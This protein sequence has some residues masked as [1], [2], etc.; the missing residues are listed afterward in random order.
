MPLALKQ[1][2]RL[3]ELSLDDVC[4]KYP[5]FPRLIAT[6]IDVQRRGVHYT[7]AALSAV[8]PKLHQVRGSYIFGARDGQLTPVPESL[9][10]RDGTTI[11][12]DTAPIEHNPYIVDLVDG[13]LWLTD[14]GTAVEPVELWPEPAYYDKVTSSGVPMKYVITARPQ[15]LNIFQ[16]GYCHFWA[17]GKGCRYCDIVTHVK[18]QRKEWGIPTRLRPQDVKET[19]IEALKEPGR[20]TNICLTAGSDTRG[21]KAFDSEVSFYIELLQAVGEV[22]KTRR[23]PSQLIATAFNEE[24]LARLYIETG[25]TSYTADIEVLNEDIFNWVCPGKAEWVGYKEW[26]RRLAAAV[27]IFGRG[28]VGNGLVGGVELARPQGFK[29]E[30]EALQRTLEEASELANRGVTTVY[31]VWV[32][33]PGSDFKDQR[34]ASLEYYVRLA[35]GLHDLRVEYGLGVDFDDYRRCGNHPDSDLARLL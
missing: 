2:S 12:A 16:S 15:R 17:N 6:K 13:A 21:E 8:D 23:F 20:F 11:L 10:L 5:Q 35:Q 22:F 32:P 9:I 27:D 34:N 28:N 29:T 31:I 25:L 26:K 18:E 30:E 14:G 24:Q 3:H 4:A 33:R 7:E 1:V 19:L